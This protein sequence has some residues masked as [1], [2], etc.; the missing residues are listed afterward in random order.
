MQEELDVEDMEIIFFAGKNDDICL[1]EFARSHVRTEK[2]LA[3]NVRNTFIL[4]FVTRGV[5]RFCDTDVP[6]GSAFLI[7]KGQLHSIRVE[8]PY[9]HTWIAFEGAGAEKLLSVFGIKSDEHVIFDVS[10]F[11]VVAEMLDTAFGRCIKADDP[12]EKGLI[13]LSALLSV[14]PYLT[15]C[16]STAKKT[17]AVGDF[18][19][20]AAAFINEHF[21]KQIT[22]KQVADYVHV[23]DKYLCRKFSERYKM[24]PKQYLTEIRLREAK[25]LLRR[26]DLK[27][28]EIAASVGY[29]S[30][31][32][33]SKSFR[34]HCGVSPSEYSVNRDNY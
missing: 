11:P 26:T 20:L 19:D 8:P 23:S 32:S 31:L 22:I 18:V 13:A 17:G 14:L 5:C 27:I 33:F 16:N 25:R 10:D 34:E 21:E 3:P 15:P 2:K 6:A 29:P 24:S 28:K 7:S 12:K 1:S 9:S 30:Q 4:H